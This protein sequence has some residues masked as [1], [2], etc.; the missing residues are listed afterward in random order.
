M[1]AA[2]YSRLLSDAPN[3]GQRLA[4]LLTTV[5]AGAIGAFY[6]NL[7]WDHAALPTIALHMNPAHKPVLNWAPRWIPVTAMALLSMLFWR[8]FVARARGI[9]IW[10]AV[11]T[12]FVLFA[13]RQGI[14]YICLDYTTAVYSEQP[15]PLWHMIAM[16]P[17]VALRAVLGA[18]IMLFLGFG[19]WI[20]MLILA[21]AA[22][23]PT[24][25]IGRLLWKWLA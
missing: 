11:I 24:A 14:E 22:G 21:C 7:Y 25:F 13:L 17:V 23:V 20:V 1:S 18:G 8:L 15:P 3:D 9:S 16:F 2:R 5:M 10:A 4:I 6:M 12:F 19:D